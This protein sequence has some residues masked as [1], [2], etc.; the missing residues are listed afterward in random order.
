MHAHTH[1]P[2]THLNLT[3]ENT[4]YIHFTSQ[5]HTLHQKPSLPAFLI[6]VSS[7]RA[8]TTT[9]KLVC[10]SPLFSFMLL[11]HRN[12]LNKTQ[13]LRVYWN[14]TQ[15]VP[16]GQ[17]TLRLWY[18]TASEI[19][20]WGYVH[21]NS[22]PQNHMVSIRHNLHLILLSLDISFY[23]L[24]FVFASTTNMAVLFLGDLFE[25]VSRG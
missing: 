6:L 2:H 10:V 8:V 4:P 15:M 18:T 11:F 13:Y 9:W 21:I 19:N 17:F 24:L 3:N 22:L 23:L 20:P 7:L 5:E 1:P 16:L 14:S 12:T 25:N